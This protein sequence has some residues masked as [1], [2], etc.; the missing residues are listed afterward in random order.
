MPE[1]FTAIRRRAVL[2][3]AAGLALGTVALGAAPAMAATP[4]EKW[5]EAKP[6]D[7][8]FLTGEWRIAN[9]RRKKAGTDDWDEFQGEATVQS[10]MGGRC[11]VE[12]LRI[13]D[14]DFAGRGLRIL[15]AEKK[16]WVDYFVNAK[17]GTLATPGTSGFVADGIVSFPG[18]EMFDGKTLLYRNIWD[19]ITATSC[20]WYQGM[21][22]DGGKTWEDDWVMAWTRV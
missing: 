13:P 18:E 4:P 20:R 22:K 17:S 11:S 6:G 1:D 10:V 12:D 9:R 19:R 3:G 14:R 15:D 5:P 2:Y 8:D 21:S 7:F 16:M